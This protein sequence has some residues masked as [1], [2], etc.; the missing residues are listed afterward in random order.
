MKVA[1]DG[2]IFGMQRYGGISRYFFEIISHMRLLGVDIQIPRYYGQNQYA[3]DD[4]ALGRLQ[5]EIPYPSFRNRIR[6]VFGGPRYVSDRLAENRRLANRWLANN[7]HRYDL[8]H[9]TYH[10]PYFLPAIGRKPFVLTVHDMFQ[11][12]YPE[13]SLQDPLLFYKRDLINRANHIV[14]VSENTKKQII[15]FLCVPH[16]KITVIH[17]GVSLQSRRGNAPTGS[18]YPRKYFLYVGR[19]SGYKNFHFLCQA[20]RPLL[21]GSKPYLLVCANENPFSGIERSYFSGLGIAENVI[22]VAANDHMLADLY[23]NAELLIVPSLYEGFSLPIA[24]AFRCEC[25][26]VAS[27]TSCHREVA[28]DAAV[29]FPPKDPSAL[30]SAV[31]TVLHNQH[32]RDELIEM[33][34]ARSEQY[35][36][37]KAAKSMQRVYESVIQESI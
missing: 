7:R 31:N 16:Q 29:F 30:R 13:Y 19:R 10:D 36:W 34:K 9:P 23:T 11:E 17:H 1:Y 27:E 28:G 14:A 5:M 32:K 33:G 2:Q 25:P 12:T 35:A 24:E 37:E 22:Q 26:V 3:A 8:F 15:D 21:S 18:Q 4:G 6:A 20:I